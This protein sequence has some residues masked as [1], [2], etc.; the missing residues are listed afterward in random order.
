MEL[1]LHNLKLAKGSKKKAK[2]VGRGN[3]SGHGTYSTRGL[4]GQRS[5][6]GGGSGLKRRGLKTLLRNK[7]K[8]GGFKSLRSKMS[9]VNLNQL[10]RFF[11]PGEVVTGKKMFEKDLVDNLNNGIKILGT[12]RLTKKLTVIADA[13]SETAKKAIMEVGGKAELRKS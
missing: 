3:S 2:R 11:E 6:S 9:E 10:D 7:P 12:G 8:I 5:R 13:F 1:G 4:K